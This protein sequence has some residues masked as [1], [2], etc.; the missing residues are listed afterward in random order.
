MKLPY[1]KWKFYRALINAKIDDDYYVVGGYILFSI[2]DIN[3][4][5]SYKTHYADR[6]MLNPLT[7]HNAWDMSL[8]K[9]I[10]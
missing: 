8:V 6:V 9:I 3:N 10:K 7:L 4:S 1:R 2:E 5:C